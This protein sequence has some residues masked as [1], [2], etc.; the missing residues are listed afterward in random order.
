VYNYCGTQSSPSTEDSGHTIQK[1]DQRG[2]GREEKH[3]LKIECKNERF[4]KDKNHTHTQAHAQM[5]LRT[6]AQRLII[7]ARI[8]LHEQK[9]S[10]VS[11]TAI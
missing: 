3:K 10:K 2:G 11:F 1:R 4:Q 7:L 8:P 5:H 9:F 6:H